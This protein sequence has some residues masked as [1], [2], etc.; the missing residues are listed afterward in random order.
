M[1]RRRLFQRCTPQ[2]TSLAV[3]NQGASCLACHQHT[4]SSWK[5]RHCTTTSHGETA[6]VASTTLLLSEARGAQSR[7]LVQPC[8]EC[9]QHMAG[10]QLPPLLLLPQPPLLVPQPRCLLDVCRPE[11]VCNARA[12]RTGLAAAA[13]FFGQVLQGR[14]SSSSATHNKSARHG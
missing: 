4:I 7:R 6:A 12:W 9:A 14:S 1:L 8:V 11:P 3:A 10:A 2:T 13:P 5:L